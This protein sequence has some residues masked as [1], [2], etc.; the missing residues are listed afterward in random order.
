MRLQDIQLGGWYRYRYTTISGNEVVLTF[1]VTEVEKRVGSYY[2]WG[3]VEN[4]PSIGR[5]CHPEQLE[6]IELTEEILE[7]NGF[8]WDG[9]GQ[10]SMMNISPFSRSETGVRYNI[11]VG[12]KYK[13][14][15]VFVAPPVEKTPGW[16]KSNKV[17]LEHCGCYVH[18]LQRALSL[19][20]IEWDIEI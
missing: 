8:K 17:Y 6:G 15:E 14:I 20:G 4:K 5:I 10:S 3:E 13:T 9:S 19:C 7:K 2:V 16:R 1:Q 11:Y 12:L 18:E